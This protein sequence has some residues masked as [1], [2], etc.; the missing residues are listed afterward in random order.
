[1][2]NLHLHLT[3]PPPSPPIPPSN[4]RQTTV[5]CCLCT[6]PRC[7]SGLPCRTGASWRAYRGRRRRSAGRERGRP[8]E[9]KGEGAVLSRTGRRGR[10]G[11]P[12]ACRGGA[13]DARGKEKPTLLPSIIYNET[14]VSFF[15][16][17]LLQ[18]YGRWRDIALKAL[19]P[20]SPPRMTIMID[21]FFLPVV[22]TALFFFFVLFHPYAF[23]CGTFSSSPGSGLCWKKDACWSFPVFFCAL[24]VLVFF[25]KCNIY[26]TGFRSFCAKNKVDYFFLEW[27]QT[28]LFAY[29]C[30]YVW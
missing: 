27:R 5:R 20:P 11:V 17:W 23:S 24:L 21:E 25:T 28:L 1:M 4:V 6:L 14:R 13:V 30:T 15:F 26:I 12:G 22:P 9:G 3:P 16:S 2:L 8:R 10:S 18:Q 29:V 7:S 19:K